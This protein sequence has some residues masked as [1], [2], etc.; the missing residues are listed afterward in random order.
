MAS[1]KS[2]YHETVLVAFNHSW[3][4]NHKTRLTAVDDKI[5]YLHA[6]DLDTREIVDT[7]KEMYY[8]DDSPILI[9][10]V[11]D[12]VLEQVIKS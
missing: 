1:F 6:K 12:V 9:S 11:T 7:L 10:K 3:S 4:K 8:A 5:H 2:T